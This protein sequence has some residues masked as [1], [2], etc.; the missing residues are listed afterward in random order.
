MRELKLDVDKA[1][2]WIRE[3]DGRR[4][5]FYASVDMRRGG[6]R[7]CPVDVNL[8][9]AGFNNLCPADASRVTEAFRAAL[10]QR[11]VKAGAAVGVVAESH[12]RNPYYAEHLHALVSLI[13]RAG[14]R[15]EA[16][17]P[18]C[19]DDTRVRSVS[20]EILNLLPLRRE[21]DRVV[22]G[23]DFVPDFLLNNNDLSTGVPEVLQ[24]PTQ[25][26][27]PPLGCGWHV[28]RKHRFFEIYA[29]LAQEFSEFM[30]I[31]PRAIMPMSLRI[32]DVDFKT[33][34]GLDHVSVAVETA[35]AEIRRWNDEYGVVE[36]PTAIVKSNYGT[37]GMAVTSVS[38][39]REI[40]E[41]NRKTVNK[42]HVGK[43]KVTTSEVLVQEGIPTEDT[44]DQCPAEPVFYM[45]DG[46]SIGAFYRHHC[47]RGNK[48]NLNVSG[49][50]FQ[51]I[52]SDSGV[53]PPPLSA[54]SVVAQLAALAAAH[55]VRSTA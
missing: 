10:E 17:C 11:G 13:R 36:P 53:L 8:F 38:D 2:A 47:E 49:M 26:I 31:D 27:T 5:L 20:G 43:G 44:V 48:Y 1:R 12:T 19:L 18:E 33:R 55:E 29:N 41:M 4:E 9:P 51:P 25:A 7:I 46:E 34:H 39:V 21:S 6:G 32:Q 42:M 15:A 30:G 54:V 14:Y 3:R 40:L 52:C 28:R 50:S 23:V 24:H 35:L 37:Y 45:M 16:G 22:F